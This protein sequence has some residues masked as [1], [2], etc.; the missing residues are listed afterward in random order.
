MRA[1]E[2]QV[3]FEAS[4]VIRVIVAIATAPSGPGDRASR[5][6]VRSAGPGA[7][8]LARRVV[9]VEPIH[10]RSVAGR[11]VIGRSGG[12]DRLLDEAVEGESLVADEVRVVAEEVLSVGVS[13]WSFGAGRS[14]SGDETVEY[15][16][17]GGPVVGRMVLDRLLSLGA[18]MAEPGEFTARAFMN[19]KLDLTRAEGVA[20]TIAAEGR[21]QLDA[22]RSLL[23]GELSR[24]LMPIME[25]CADLLAVV[26]AGIDF[27]D[28]DITFI[29]HEQVADR[30][31]MMLREVG[32]LLEESPRLEQIG[33]VPRLVLVGRPNAGKSTLLN[34]L[35]GQRRA[36]VSEMPGTT[37]DVI[38]SRLKL[39]RGTVEVCDVAGLDDSA[40]PETSVEISDAMQRQA[41][42]AVAEADVVIGVRAFDDQRMLPAI[43][44]AYDVEVVTQIDRRGVLTE[45]SSVSSDRSIVGGEISR[46]EVS[47]RAGCGM[48]ELQRHLD[49][50]AFGVR[51]SRRRAGAVALSARHVEAL[52]RAR[53]AMERA[54][55][56]A[57][58]AGPIELQAADLRWALDGL[59]E[60]LG[61][62][63]PDDVLGRVFS[64]FCIGK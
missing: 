41:R 48:D 17:P 3:E 32:G 50:L 1:D 23:A 4:G 33:R 60:V 12:R 27:S 47:A 21:A 28:E 35:I 5:A 62:V 30:V 9:G 22:A 38:A 45:E 34:A 15:H 44:R 55:D 31:E 39:E 56:Q 25:A 37:R 58:Q 40:A 2:G 51:V 24:R 59:G 43:D 36:V 53:I 6:V 13:L 54:R 11:F 19:G 57:R 10:A 18:R 61:S 46:L 7:F 52:G 8:E 26:E 29:A 42:R 64:R 63:S 14:Y 49:G 16:V 20:L